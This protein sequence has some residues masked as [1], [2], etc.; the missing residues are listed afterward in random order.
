MRFRLLLQEIMTNVPAQN[1]SVNAHQ[2]VETSFDWAKGL[3]L[4]M[5]HKLG[6]LPVLIIIGVKKSVIPWRLGQGKTLYRT[7]DAFLVYLITSHA[8]V[9]WYKR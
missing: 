1:H 7:H 3:I 8:V 6:Y 2:K 9:L 5:A 4:R